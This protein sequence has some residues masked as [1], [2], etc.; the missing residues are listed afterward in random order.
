MNDLEKRLVALDLLIARTKPIGAGECA[1]SRRTNRSEVSAG[2]DRLM[3]TDNPYRS[4]P[5]PGA[6]VV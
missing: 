3:E 1:P 4:S 5:L 6:Y 2:S